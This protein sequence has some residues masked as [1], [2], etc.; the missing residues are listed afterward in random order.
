MHHGSPPYCDVG[1][2]SRSEPILM[3]KGRSKAIISSDFLPPQV[4]EFKLQSNIP[5]QPGIIRTTLL[6]LIQLESSYPLIDNMCWSCICL[7]NKFLLHFYIW[8]A[9]NVTQVS[10]PGCDHGRWETHVSQEAS[11]C[12]IQISVIR[13]QM[14]QSSM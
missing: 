6:H 3:K 12:S 10:C 4:S 2:G 9:S 11:L 8:D 13:P 14:E 7:P 1:F 5:M